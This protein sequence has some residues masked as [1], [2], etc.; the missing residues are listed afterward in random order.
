VASLDLS[1]LAVLRYHGD[2]AVRAA[3]GVVAARHRRAS[4]EV[5][6]LGEAAEGL[7]LLGNLVMGECLP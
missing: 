6:L 1:A 4:D 5:A 3:T 7:A 2:Q